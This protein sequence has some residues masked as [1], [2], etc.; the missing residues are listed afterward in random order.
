MRTIVYD[1]KTS[2][3]TTCFPER[4]VCR[5]TSF[6]PTSHPVDEPAGPSSD[7]KS[8]LARES[9]GT[10]TMEG[11]EVVGTRETRTISPGAFGN[12]RPVVVV[13]EIWYSPQ[14]QFNL[15]VTRIDPRNGTQKLEV[16]DLKLG[17]PGPEWFAIPDG[18]RQVTERT[19]LNRAAGPAELEPL[20]EKIVTGI[21]PEQL[22]T[23]LQPVEAAIGAYAKAHAEAA[24]KDRNDAFA[25]Q[26]RTRLSSDLRIM[27]QQSFPSSL[28]GANSDVRLN[29][30]Y[31]EVA[32]SP[33][34]DKPQPGDPPSMPSSKQTFTAEENAWLALR[35]TWKAF[36]VTLFPNADRAELGWMFTNDR[37]N[38]LRKLEGVER[39]RGCIPEEPIAP[40]LTGVVSDQTTE[41][42]SG[43]LK[44]VEAAIGA[45][46]KAHIEASPKDNNEFLTRQLDQRLV[47]DLR[48][49]QQNS[50]PSRAQVA[51]ADARLNQMYHEVADS[52][53]LD[54]PQ[55]GDPPSMPS[56]KQ[57]LNAEENAW[58]AI[59]DAW[60]AFLITLFPNADKAGLGWSLTNDRTN[61][62]RRLQNVERNRGCIPEESIAPLLAGMVPGQTP[63]QLSA[64]L[65]PVD[66]AIGAYVK[67][68]IEA[69]PKDRNES[70]ADQTRSR[71]V[72]DLQMLQ[73]NPNLSRAQVADAD[74]RLNQMFLQVIDSPCLDK[75]QPGDP[76][77]IPTS[78]EALSAERTRG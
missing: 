25:G 59:R 76:Q 38:D 45:Y 60:G 16:T 46:V 29:Q 27:Q 47:A 3:I 28:R 18:Y 26:V 5:Q 56:S 17:E 49:L 57:A 63:E 12:D 2:L 53:C 10:K 14:L 15:S 62:L 43:A 71:L 69:A 44:P 67:A 51:D 36:L 9:L 48:V 66:A 23:A 7:G 30:M 58:L 33:C 20:L 72:S 78:K 1:P 24:P 50:N 77:S 70:F 19:M 8:V 22:T 4:R 55:P 6:D 64:A 34:I 41:Q 37:F 40:L 42:L 52:P 13:K 32:D 74:L 61:D 21:S 65:K 75:P 11:L 31:Q 68:Y 54:K 73:Q 35:D 39:N